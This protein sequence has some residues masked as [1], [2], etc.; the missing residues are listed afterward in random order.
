MTIRR[1]ESKRGQMQHNDTD[2]APIGQF[3]PRSQ[4]VS[5][6]PLKGRAALLYASRFHLA[7]FPTHWRDRS[8]K[9]SCRHGD[10]ASPAKHPLTPHGCLDASLDA[11]VI[12]GWW[13]SWPNANLA[14]ATG[15]RSGIAVLDVDP[16]HSGD[17]GLAALE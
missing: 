17:E 6:F 13:R 14:I 8:G 2:L 5:N 12:R 9:C 10:C 3:N 16:R 4:G 7:V 11:G 1:A 15:A